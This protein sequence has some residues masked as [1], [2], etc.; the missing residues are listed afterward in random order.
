[1]TKPTIVR[2]PSPAARRVRSASLPFFGTLAAD[3]RARLAALRDSLDALAD[4]PRRSPNERAAE[5]RRII[6]EAKSWHARVAAEADRNLAGIVATAKRVAEAVRAVEFNL[7][8]LEIARMERQAAALAALPASERARDFERAFE[9]RDLVRLLVHGFGDALGDGG[10]KA[11][12]VLVAQGDYQSLA[13]DEGATVAQAL[14]MREV[15][16]GLAELAELEDPHT[17][18]SVRGGE[19]VDLGN[20]GVR[21][22]ADDE[23]IRQALPAADVP[24]WLRS[25]LLPPRTVVA[26]QQRPPS[27][28]P[29]ASGGAA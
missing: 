24:P 17:K 18:A 7:S 14:A 4:D 29:Q 9:A 15:G 1:M 21:A 25:L 11:V 23:A 22:I 2:P 26:E 27:D 3:S 19:L 13:L 8:P 28:E 12:A 16:R 6:G 20:R 5:A 10:R